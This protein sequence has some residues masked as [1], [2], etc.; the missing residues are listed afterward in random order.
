MY[1]N[2]KKLV[3]KIG[4]LHGRGYAIELYSMDEN[5]GTTEVD[6][7]ARYLAFIY[8]CIENVELYR[9]LVSEL[10]TNQLQEVAASFQYLTL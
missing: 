2:L 3:D 4:G 9:G 1:L 6:L 8:Y 5:G 7:H 10:Q